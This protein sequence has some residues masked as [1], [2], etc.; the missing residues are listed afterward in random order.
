[1]E[2]DIS[3]LH[4]LDILTLQRPDASRALTGRRARSTIARLGFLPS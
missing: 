3:T 2:P 1:M 4:N